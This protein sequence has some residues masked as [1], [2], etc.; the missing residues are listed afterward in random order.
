M[1]Q[2]SKKLQQDGK[3]LQQ[4]GKSCNKMARVATTKRKLQ[5]HSKKSH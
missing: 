2:D 5:Q 3:K 4:D 1:Q